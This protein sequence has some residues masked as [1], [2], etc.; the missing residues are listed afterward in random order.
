VL[1][2]ALAAF[3]AAAQQTSRMPRIGVLWPVGEHLYRD[4]FVQGLREHGHAEGRTLAI[5]YRYARG[6]EEALPRLA[7]EL[8]ELKVD[9]ILAWGTPA[10]QAARQATATTPIVFVAVGDPVAAGLAS[11]LAHPGRNVTGFTPVAGDLERKR[12]EVLKEVVPRAVRIGV[13]WNPESPYS[14]LALQQTEIAARALTLRLHPVGLRGSEIGE[15]L[16][17]LARERPDALLVHGD[18]SLATLRNRILEF[19]DTGRVPA[20]YA[21]PDFAEAGGLMSYGASYPDLFRR[22]AGYVDR[23]LKGTKPGDLPIQQPTKFELVVNLKTARTLG[24]TVPQPVLL[25]A[26][27]VIR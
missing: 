24:L 15:A 19:A 1:A 4:A 26:D 27:K 10:A 17:A 25:L 3:P 21:W 5:E 9:A 7:A 14:A 13:L 18:P 6:R 22:A 8:V 11:S 12:L 20:M 2:A 23:I 16:A